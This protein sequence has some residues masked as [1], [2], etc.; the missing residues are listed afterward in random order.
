M[1]LVAKE[2]LACRT[3]HQGVLILS[4]FAGAAAELAE[5]TLVNPLDT[6]ELTDA[7][8]Q[9]L[10]MPADEQRR[11]MKTM[12]RRLTDYDVTCWVN[13]FLQQLTAAKEQQTT[14]RNKF[15][16]RP[17]R[18]HMIHRYRVAHKR[19]LFLDYDGTLVPF[20]RFP[21]DAKPDAALLNLLTALG[22]D[23]RNSV[24]VISGRETATLEEWFGQLPINLV[25]EH[26][27]AVKR[28]GRGWQYAGEIDQGWKPEVRPTLDM[29]V[30]RCPGS[31][32]EEKMHTLAWHYRNVDPDLGFA[33]S[34]ELIENLHLFIRNANL[35]VIDGNKVIEV[36][37]SGVDKG[38]AARH[39]L[40]EDP[41]DF[42]L[43]I[44]DDKTDEDMFRAL[45][46]RAVT[47]KVGDG[48]SAAQNS[49]PSQRDVIRLLT[50]FAAA[51]AATADAPPRNGLVGADQE[52]AA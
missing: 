4:E 22:S 21:Q 8:A 3:D 24:T 46:D 44:G 11:K 14:E 40:D 47:I 51:S 7:I 32:V 12:Q 27:A 18:L 30:K 39:F 35:Q 23:P 29:F 43:A 9:A 36:R 37:V 28:I 16:T 2:Y 42:V 5:A 19:H 34:R 26:G 41:A 25:A 38:A 48:H 45:A 6:Q 13:D 15:I 20:A 52:K 10:T 49:L 17:T 50:D 1:N 31:F 33:R